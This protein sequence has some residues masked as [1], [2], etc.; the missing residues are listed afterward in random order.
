MIPGTSTKI[1]I[2]SNRVVQE[3]PFDINMIY[4]KLKEWFENHHYEYSETENT[5]N[6]KPKGAN[7]KIKM[8]GERLVTEYYKF[9]ININFQIL[10]TEKVK[11]KDKVL[12]Y[13]NLEAREEV[14]LEL[15]YKKK[16][17]KSKFGKFI[18]FVY[19]NYIIKQ[20]ILS[21]YCGKAY[22]EGMSLF[23]TLKDAI[24]LYTE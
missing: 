12:D 17:D 2:F 20:Q 14:I 5:T 8:K 4:K 9:T 7:L 6:L 22:G 3:G 13:G 11:I 23:E 16:F 21:E 18:R 24:G 19:N 15:D 1:P 10:D